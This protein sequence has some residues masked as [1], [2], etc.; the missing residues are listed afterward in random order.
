[1][2]A[3]REKDWGSKPDGYN[4]GDTNRKHYYYFALDVTDPRKAA[5]GETEI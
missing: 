2:F 5:K 4:N 3:G 1:L